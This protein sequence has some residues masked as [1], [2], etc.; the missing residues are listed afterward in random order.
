MPN[1]GLLTRIAEARA[2]QHETAAM[3]NLSESVEHPKFSES[4]IEERAKAA[5]YRHFISVLTELAEHKEP[6]YV[7]NLTY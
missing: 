7:V 3:N 5:R 6:H 1:V 2:I 4:M